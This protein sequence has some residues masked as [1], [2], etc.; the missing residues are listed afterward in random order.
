MPPDRLTGAVSHA[1]TASASTPK[2]PLHGKSVV[3]A[4]RFDGKGVVLTP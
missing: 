2:R 3:F 4:P 1:S